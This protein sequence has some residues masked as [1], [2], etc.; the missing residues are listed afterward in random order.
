MSTFS[1]SLSGLKAAE[2][3]M[4]V[5]SQNIA[6][7]D[8]PN[9]Q[10]LDAM[11]S[12][13]DFSGPDNKPFIP[14]GVST[15][16]KTASDPFADHRV[17]VALA[18][19]AYDAAVQ[20]GL[21]QLNDGVR[22]QNVEQAFSG[23]MNAT[24]DLNINP[25]DPVRQTAFSNAG[26][27]FSTELKGLGDQFSSVTRQITSTRDYK[28]IQ[29]SN[30]Q[31]SM[32]NITKGPSTPEAQAELSAM[33]KQVILL[34]NSVDGYN[35]VLNGVIPPIYSMFAT[36][37]QSVVNGTNASY[38]QNIIN[39]TGGFRF[40]ATNVG[41]VKALTEF[42]SQKFNQ[43]MGVINTDMGSKL[44]GATMENS[45]AQSA[46]TM[47]QKALQASTGVDLTYQT[48]KMLEYQKMYEANAK[49]I[50]VQ[51]SLLGTILSISA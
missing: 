26:Q 35:K 3:G 30:L 49:V 43:D 16:I 13:V 18:N 33:Q 39:D 20:D 34:S 37:Q 15:D 45:G 10:R 9:Y 31:Q 2:T 14:G 40:D 47:A 19:A 7:V 21:Q 36:A 51:N 27:T 29:L 8:T 5:V 12:T 1:V 48:V 25:K 28:Q 50:Q 17:N 4:S 24:Q 22:T 23:F 44:V 38:G 11:F 6:N 42:G 41:N 46:L 32:S